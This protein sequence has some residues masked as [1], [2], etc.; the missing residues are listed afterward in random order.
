MTITSPT[1]WGRSRIGLPDEVLK[2]V[3][4]ESAERL[5][6]PPARAGG[7]NSG[8]QEPFPPEFDYST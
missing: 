4:F 3:Y 2:K 7:M 8:F 6:G 1:A 5:Y